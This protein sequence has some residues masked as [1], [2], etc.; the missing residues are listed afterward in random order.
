MPTSST[1]TTSMDT[2]S[3]DTTSTNTPSNSPGRPKTVVEPSREIQLAGAYDVAVVGGGMAGIGAAIAAARN[4]AKVCLIERTCT[5][6]GLAT[7]GN[8]TVWLVLCDGMGRQVTSGLAEELLHLSVAD[9][10]REIPS[11]GFV[12]VP[13]RWRADGSG[14]SGKNARYITQFNP[15]SYMLALEALV[16]RE[17]VEIMYD[18]RLCNVLTAD[19]R[20]HHLVI[21]NKSGRSAIECATVIDA[22]GDADVCYLAGEKTESVASNVLAGWFYYL[23][24]DGLKLVKMTN[25]YS[26]FADTEGAEGPFFR[27]DD[28]KEVTAQVL[29][30]REMMRQRLAEIRERN[31]G[32]D[33]QILTPPS[34]PCLRMTRRLVG[35][36]SLGTHHKHQW[37]DDAVGI[38]GDWR[39][40]G[41]VYAIPWRTLR[42]VHNLNLTAVGRCMSSD[43][44]V[45]DVTRGISACVLTGEAAG[46][47]SAMAVKNHGGDL[48]ALPVRELQ[49]RL[50]D[51]GAFLDPELVKPVE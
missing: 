44:T 41:P 2:R 10:K 7:A 37:F 23:V 42:G 47:A 12:G 4:G 46:T 36:M 19:G 28:A 6:G 27:G 33:P 5:L 24:D 26:P 3:K 43:T 21:E 29:G 9:L 49:K 11:A 48:S 13:P 31:P 40:R 34:I 45:W 20:V 14:D 39:R 30:S 17:G 35:Q 38:T 51:Q 16:V 15:S 25:K 18:T 8:V 50:I 1:H 22:S 32:Q